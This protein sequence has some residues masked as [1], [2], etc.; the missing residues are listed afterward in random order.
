MREY[1]S[2][3]AYGSYCYAKEGANSRMALVCDVQSALADRVQ[4]SRHVRK[5]AS[6]RT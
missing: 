2:F 4:R 5:Q 3:D 1:S 6:D